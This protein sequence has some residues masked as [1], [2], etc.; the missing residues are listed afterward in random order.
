MF[1][2]PVK[3]NSF[4]LFCGVVACLFTTS[5]INPEDI[6]FGNTKLTISVTDCTGRNRPNAIV[7]TTDGKYSATTDDLGLATLDLPNAATPTSYTL[8][9]KDQRGN[10]LSRRD[11]TITTDEKV[12]TG[13]FELP[14]KCDGYVKFRCLN[15][16]DVP[17][18]AHTLFGIGIGNTTFFPMDSNK[19]TFVMPIRYSAT[20]KGIL[21][22]IAKNGNSGNALKN[23]STNIP[24]G[25]TIQ[26]GD[27]YGERLGSFSFN[28]NGTPYSMAPNEYDAAD[29]RG[30]H[31]FQGQFSFGLLN[32]AQ[33]LYLEFPLASDPL[34][35]GTFPII[36]GKIS[37]PSDEYYPTA[38]SSITITKYGSEGRTIEGTFSGTWTKGAPPNQ[39]NLSITNGQFKAMNLK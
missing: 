11:T 37:L 39:V 13:A 17:T 20:E 14:V 34:G 5:C 33:S 1:K 16:N 3:T 27:V 7:V 32:I 35:T 10:T 28:A 30:A 19:T 12:P 36:G 6:K 24:L 15:R 4:L 21:E 25:D 9:V 22:V 26:L 31:I 8:R 29:S 2:F 38:S 18:M 23:I